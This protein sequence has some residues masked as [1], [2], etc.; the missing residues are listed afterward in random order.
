MLRRIVLL[1]VCFV[2]GHFPLYA[3]P[4]TVLV[5]GDSLSAGYGVSNEQSWVSLL[6]NRLSEHGY[7]YTVV[8]ASVSGDTTSQG[9][10]KLPAALE[11]HQPTVVI[12][13]LGG[14]DGLRAL[15]VD[16]IRQNLAQMIQLS[17]A[18]NAKVLLVGTRLPPN[19]GP[20]YVSAFEHI[21]GELAR[22]YQVALAPFL[23]QGVATDSRLMQEDGIHPN[24]AGHR[25]MLDTLWPQL[26]GLLDPL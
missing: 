3:A 15:A 4:G 17:Q 21:Y 23:M 5:V 14:N 16:M 8:N 6:Q 12:I 22:Q 1:T 25:R 7:K 9:L 11:H 10:T 26:E 19:Y 18:R 13:E 20:V 2:A 24:P